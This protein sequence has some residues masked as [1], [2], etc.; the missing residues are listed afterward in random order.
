M[1]ATDLPA[2]LVVHMFPTDDAV[3]QQRVHEVLAA[4]QPLDAD[5]LASTLEERLQAVYPQ[6]RVRRRASLAGFG[7][8]ALYV[9][10]DGG[11]IGYD[12]SDSWIDRP[13]TARVVS[14]AT[15]TYV[16]ANEAAA[17]LFGVSCAEIIGRRA[18]DFTRPDTHVDAGALWEVLERTGR[19]HSFAVVTGAKGERRVEFITI[20][21][22]DGPGRNVTYLREHLVGNS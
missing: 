11:A 4:D 18:G 12:S 10:R 14:D 9:F 6:L 19:L 22:G 7:Q 21:D 3:L 5:A 8:T 16:A 15:G 17:A 2:N 20:K 1:T 13:S